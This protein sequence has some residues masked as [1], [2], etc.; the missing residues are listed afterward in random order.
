ML[1]KAAF[2]SVV[3]LPGMIACGL[4]LLFATAG[5]VI[6][7]SRDAE[8]FTRAVGPFQKLARDVYE[9]QRSIWQA[10]SHCIVFDEVLFYKPRPGKCEFNNIEFSTVLTFDKKGFR[11]TS[12]PIP[13]NDRPNRVIVLGDSQAMGWGVQDEETFASV[14]AAEHG[15]EVFNLAVSSYGTARELLRL[16]KE[17][18]LRNGDIVVIQYHQNDLHENLA[19][20]KSGGLPGHSPSDLDLLAHTPQKYEVLQVT[21]SIAFIL[22]GRLDKSMKALFSNSDVEAGSVEHHA[23]TF[24]AVIDHFREL[25]RARV[26]V[27][28]VP[29]FGQATHFP[30][31]L[32]RLV[33]GRM[34]VL[35]PVWETSEFYTLDPHLNSR[36]HRKL[37]NLIAAALLSN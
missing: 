37:A 19:F 18:N 28:E 17:F 11:Q 15:F 1:K 36:G 26:V 9:R 32:K 20:L 2:W 13:D 21:A 31:D 4:L 25:A 27:C 29:S 7:I 3:F 8:A 30:E 22:K 6:Y 35:R 34:T 24:L 23:K 33:E 10:Q 12:P 5:F 14:L 16:Q